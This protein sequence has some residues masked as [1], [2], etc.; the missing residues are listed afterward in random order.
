MTN[1]RPYNEKT[2]SFG[3]LKVPPNVNFTKKHEVIFIS[4]FN[5]LLGQGCARSQVNALERRAA[6]T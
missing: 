2:K 3:S 6:C 4:N 5:M 1:G